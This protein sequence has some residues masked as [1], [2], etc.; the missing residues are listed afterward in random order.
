MKRGLVVTLGAIVNPRGWVVS[1]TRTDPLLR[2]YLFYWDR[3]DYPENPVVETGLS[4]DAQLLFDEGIL[5]RTRVQQASGY[6][7][8]ALRRAQLEAFRMREETEP[9]AWA[10]AQSALDVVLLPDGPPNVRG[11]TVELVDALPIPSYDTPLEKL[12]RFKEEREPELLAL[13]G[14]LDALYERVISSADFPR[15]K[16]GAIEEVEC[17][18]ADLTKV[19]GESFL[20][21]FAR[22]LKISLNAS[23][24]L[25][26]AGAGAFAAQQFGLAT[27]GWAVASGAVGAVGSMIRFDLGQGPKFALS[28]ETKAFSYVHSVTREFGL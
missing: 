25:A 24:V 21:R 27:A 28:P 9:G 3:L 12:L 6:A 17:A 15:A 18:I 13:W 14:R 23:Q 8:E 4:E 7:L 1:P 26:G 11:V 22:S 19:S 10:L 2:S 20:T 16:A 5:T